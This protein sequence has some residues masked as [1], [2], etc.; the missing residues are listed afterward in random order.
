MKFILIS[1][2]LVVSLFSFSQE[3]DKCDDAK[4]IESPNVF[5]QVIEYAQSKIGLRYGRNGFDCSG[6]VAKAFNTIGVELP[7]SSKMQSKLGQKVAKTEAK[8][9]DLIFFSSPRSGKK[10]VGHVGIVTEVTNNVVHFVHAAVKGGIMISKLTESYYQKHFI[11]I[12]R[13]QIEAQLV[14]N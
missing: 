2:L 12:K 3:I 14:Q 4:N 6:L 13:N 10:K 8:P 11:S 9:G 1:I 7:H 5:N